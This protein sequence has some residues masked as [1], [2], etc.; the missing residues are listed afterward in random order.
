VTLLP[1]HSAIFCGLGILFLT[2]LAIN[3]SRMRVR[4]RIFLGDGDVAAL[5]IAVRTHGNAL[6]HLMPMLF[7]LVIYELLGARKLL[8]DIFGAV[9]LIARFTHAAAYLAH[10]STLRRVGVALTYSVEAVLGATVIAQAM[11]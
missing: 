9:I 11:R 10:W 8:V 7:L 2:G 5:Q 4:H 1:S 6:E 3:I